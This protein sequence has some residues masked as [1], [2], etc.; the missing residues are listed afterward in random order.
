[1]QIWE[2]PKIMGTFLG[3]Y[4]KENSDLGSILGPP[5]FGKLPYNVL[6]GGMKGTNART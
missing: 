2:F 4:N 5:Y 3:P 1:M 6:E